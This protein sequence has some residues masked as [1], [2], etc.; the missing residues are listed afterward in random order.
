ME[1]KMV[2]K[3]GGVCWGVAIIMGVM[4]FANINGEKKIKFIN[5]TPVPTT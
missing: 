4:L 1:K 5:V 3:V 2:C